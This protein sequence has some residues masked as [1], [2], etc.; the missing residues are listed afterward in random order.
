MA[1]SLAWFRFAYY[2][3]TPLSS[4]KDLS[5][6]SFP[7]SECRLNIMPSISVGFQLPEQVWHADCNF[8]P[9]MTALALDL[10]AAETLKRR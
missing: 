2:A 7:A 1:S 9:V 10:P 5:Q 3:H 4:K 8:L 6:S